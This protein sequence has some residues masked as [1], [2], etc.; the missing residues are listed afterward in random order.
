MKD[1]LQIAS[2]LRQES[3]RLYERA[4]AIQTVAMIAEGR[5]HSLPDDIR[6]TDEELLARMTP[7]QRKAYDEGVERF[8]RRHQEA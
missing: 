1:A 6:A 3:L 5:H 4:N 2:E 7:E 8:E